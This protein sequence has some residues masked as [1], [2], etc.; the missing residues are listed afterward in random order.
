M[1]RE[2]DEIFAH[3][4]NSPIFHHPSK[5]FPDFL[6]PDQNF[7]PFFFLTEIRIPS[8]FSIVNVFVD[9]SH[10]IIKYFVFKR[11]SLIIKNL[12][13]NLLNTTRYKTTM[14]GKK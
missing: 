11:V 13:W 10:K 5:L 2:S 6:I 9:V 1:S 12:K 3:R 7:F 8:K 4:N 14:F